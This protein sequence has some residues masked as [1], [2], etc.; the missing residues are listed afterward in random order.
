MA[1][2]RCCDAF[3][4]EVMPIQHCVVHQ[5]RH[6]AVEQPLLIGHRRNQAARVPIGQVRHGFGEQLEPNHQGLQRLAISKLLCTRK[7]TIK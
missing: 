5:P 6:F 1:V 2:R 4:K 3:T 7:D